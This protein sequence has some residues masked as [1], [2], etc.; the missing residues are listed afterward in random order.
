MFFKT[1][2]PAKV[3]VDKAKVAAA[4]HD[5]KICLTGIL[6]TL[7]IPHISENYMT[8][9]KRYQ[10]L[11]EAIKESRGQDFYIHIK[12]VDELNF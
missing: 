9:I 7:R 5:T 6:P 12:G 10:A 11:N 4:K 8:K 3:F 2:Q 1:T